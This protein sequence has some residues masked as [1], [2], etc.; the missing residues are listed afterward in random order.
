M[1]QLPVK[2]WM[3]VMEKSF[4]WMEQTLTKAFFLLY[5]TLTFMRDTGKE[6]SF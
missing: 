2:A 3:L 4:G 6:I 1:A 5:P